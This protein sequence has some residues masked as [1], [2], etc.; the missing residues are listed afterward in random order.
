MTLHLLKSITQVGSNTLISRLFGLI[1]DIVI[2]NSF[3][4]SAGVDGFLVAFRLPNFLR[5][6]FAE[7]AFSQAFIPVLADYQKNHSLEDVRDLCSH[8]SG[9]LGLSV[10][11]V[12]IAGVLGA[13]F[14][15][16]VF[17][18]GFGGE[19]DK[20]ALTVEMTRL[21]FPYLFFISL[22]GFA[23]SVL[24]AYGRFGVPAFVPVLLNW[25]L[26]AATL[27]LS[28]YM[29]EPVTALAWGVF[30]AGVVQLIFHIP[31]LMRL[32]LLVR[33][34]FQW[35]H[36]GVARIIR[37]MVPGIIGVSVVQVNLLI[38]TLIASFL[39]TG[40]VTWL[41]YADRMVE[42][43]LGVF[44]IALATVVLPTLSR[45]HASADRRDFSKTLDW[46]LRLV[47]VIGLPSTIALAILATPILSTLF[48]YGEFG[49]NDV[50]NASVALI[51][52]SIGLVG[53][54]GI[55][56]L[57]AGFYS[58]EDMKTP[59]R[60]ALIA[61]VVNLILNLSFVGIMGHAGLALATSISALLNAVLL[62]RILVENNVLQLRSGWGLLAARVFV[63]GVILGIVLWVLR[64]SPAE[65]SYGSL[66]ER[67]LGLGL[68]LVGGVITY[69]G[70]L[71]VTGF[72]F[73][74]LRLK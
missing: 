50:Y 11:L 27:W 59:V 14:F 22:A 7:G 9:V 41:Y 37:I 30:L 32:G 69:F 35:R 19:P 42:F 66:S 64:D 51:A 54:M 16:M 3:G 71:L 29:E 68:C 72:R 48:E 2:A 63:A 70:A 10:L 21:T 73:S 65:L 31:F 43:P 1:R 28:P 44:G 5:R 56:V 24:N 18:P 67:S 52:Y 60:V 62:L 8:V 46:S 12:S 15:V 53:F 36:S 20:F 38:D 47:F 49:S 33:P 25:C 39:V 58:R 13:P 61:M 23:S 26:I 34:R 4:A 40:T 45:L 74:D 6:L 57:A 17:A 55:K